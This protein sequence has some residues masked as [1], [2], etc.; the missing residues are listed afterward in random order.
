MS[1]ATFDMFDESVVAEKVEQG[2]PRSRLLKEL[3]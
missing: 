3:F 2:P 1:E